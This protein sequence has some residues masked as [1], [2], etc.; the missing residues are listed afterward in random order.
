MVKKAKAQ[1]HV[2]QWPADRQKACFCGERQ[3]KELSEW[4][5]QGSKAANLVC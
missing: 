2:E 3:G 4:A 1:S 5:W